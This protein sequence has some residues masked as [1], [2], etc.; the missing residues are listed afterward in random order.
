MNYSAVLFGGLKAGHVLRTMQL[1]E[2][3][4][5]RNTVYKTK[6]L[7]LTY[8]TKAA[9]P[10]LYN[11]MDNT[12]CRLIHRRLIEIVFENSDVLSDK[13]YLELMNLKM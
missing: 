9:I 2:V 8:K 6:K 4:A 13:E 7:F 3:F 10:G 5:K 11:D 12:I 1:S